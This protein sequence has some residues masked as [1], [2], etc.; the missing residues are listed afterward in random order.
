MRG[1][2]SPLGMIFVALVFA[3]ISGIM[4]FGAFSQ[5]F[6]MGR[7]LV[8]IVGAE[9]MSVEV[10]DSRVETV[11]IQATRRR[12]RDSVYYRPLVS[13][14]YSVGG[15]A[16]SGTRVTPLNEHAGSEW[17]GGLAARF[18]PGRT[19]QGYYD[20]DRP[21]EAF[22]VAEIHWVELVMGL[23]AALMASPGCYF[24]YSIVRAFRRAGHPAGPGLDSFAGS[25]RERRRQQLAQRRRLPRAQP[26][27]LNDFTL[28]LPPRFGGLMLLSTAGLI[29][30]LGIALE[31][32]FLMLIPAGFLGAFGA[33][34]WWVEG[35]TAFRPP[36]QPEPEAAPEDSGEP[37]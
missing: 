25:R 24:V 14:S 32:P 20:P 15:R 22:L 29:A 2:S 5:F 28:D 31:H 27:S 7:A 23:F 16:Y 19:Y 4:L 35:P 11:Y 26:A 10:T 8:H 33:F 6:E 21:G 37:Y 9:R 36:S 1:T 13:Y 12:Q 34:L 18:Q 30:A 3:I 17:A